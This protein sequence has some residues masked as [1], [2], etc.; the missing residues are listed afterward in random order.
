LT[1]GELN[2][3]CSARERVMAPDIRHEPTIPVAQQGKRLS[4]RNHRKFTF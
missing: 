2:A 3:A 1:G 4:S